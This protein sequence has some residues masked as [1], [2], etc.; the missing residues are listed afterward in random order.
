[1]IHL[2]KDIDIKIPSGYQ[3]LATRLRASHS[4]QSH[5]PSTALFGSQA[6][7]TILKKNTSDVICTRSALPGEEAQAK[8]GKKVAKSTLAIGGAALSTKRT[9]KGDGDQGKAKAEG[10][11]GTQDDG[12]AWA[13]LFKSAPNKCAVH[14]LR[15][16]LSHF[17]HF[18][19]GPG[20]MSMLLLSLC[21][22]WLTC[23]CLFIAV[24]GRQFQQ[25]SFLTSGYVMFVAIT[26]LADFQAQLFWPAGNAVMKGLI[27]RSP[28]VTN[29][30][31]MIR[32]T[33]SVASSNK[34]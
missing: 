17:W 26:W 15:W 32:V 9:G 31:C 13:W 14:L 16:S 24:W 10:G 27:I 30:S 4:H 19:L 34:Q 18:V 2:V 22:Q 11:E 7:H 5:P 28:D 6:V 20:W 33:K 23:H 21:V 1:M 12:D 25:P 29:S 3:L 8:V